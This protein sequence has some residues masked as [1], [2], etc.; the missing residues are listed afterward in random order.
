MTWI[1]AIASFLGRLFSE[2]I[3]AIGAEIR[4]NNTV[5]HIGADRET[6]DAIDLCITDSNGKRVR[7]D[8]TGDS[9]SS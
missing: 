2:L 8:E 3:P 6:K 4:K 1:L 7:M 9:G 5:K